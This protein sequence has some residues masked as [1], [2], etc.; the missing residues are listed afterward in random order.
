MRSG[1][2]KAKMILRKYW[3]GKVPVDPT[4][5]AERLYVKVIADSE[6]VWEGLSG[7][8]AYEDNQPVIRYNPH[9]PPNRQRFTIAHEIG[10]FVLGHNGVYRDPKQFFSIAHY[11]PKEAACNK[12]AAELLMPEEAIKLFIVTLGIDDIESLARHFQVSEVAM[13]YRLENLGWIPPT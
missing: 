7:K 4:A 10:H 6:L 12:F 9:E 8:F 2:A 13:K 11:D 3:D 1:A 5:I